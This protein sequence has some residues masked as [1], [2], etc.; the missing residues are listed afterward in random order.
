MNNRSHSTRLK[1]RLLAAF[2]DMASHTDGR[3]I[4]LTFDQHLGGAIRKACDH[5]REALYLA[6]AAQIVRQGIFNRK[7]SFTGS[8]Q[9]GCQKDGIPTALLALIYMIQE[10][11]NIEYQTQ[12][13]TSSCSNSALSIAQ[14]LMFNSVKHTL[15]DRSTNSLHHSRDRESPL[16]IYVALKIHCLTRKRRLIDIFY[17]L[18]MCVSYD[19]LLQITADLAQGICT[20]F[21][22][23]QIVCPP[24]M[25]HK[26]FTIGAVDNIDHNPT[27]TTAH[28]SFHGTSISIIQQLSHGVTGNKRDDLVFNMDKS[29]NRSVPPLR[30][31]Y[32]CVPLAALKTKEFKVPVV[33]GPVK[34]PNFQ[35]SVQAKEEEL[36]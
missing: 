28:D 13:Y 20:R 4:L 17:S 26:L 11:S 27:S 3:D 30:S 34:P 10:G 35:L 18:G 14:L 33:N 5:D 1:T 31:S 19:R 24:K 15:S 16:P 21:E 9:N 25:R 2:P 23:D 7:F 22:A 32:T 29:S 36:K 8:F 6:R 12:V